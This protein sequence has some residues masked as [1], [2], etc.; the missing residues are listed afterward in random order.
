MIPPEKR[1]KEKKRNGKVKATLNQ[2]P[3]LF[4]KTPD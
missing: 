3:M 2:A 1:A 4:S